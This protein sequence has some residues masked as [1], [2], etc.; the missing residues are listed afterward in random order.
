VFDFGT[1][2]PLQLTALPPAVGAAALILDPFTT[3][4]FQR[5]AL[6]WARA[7]QDEA[8]LGPLEL[9]SDLLPGG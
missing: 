4:E 5:A 2:T 3:G 7:G 6:W 1:S 8:A 9:G